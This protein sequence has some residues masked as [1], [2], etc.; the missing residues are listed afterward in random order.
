MAVT[1]TIRMK[2]V[3][4]QARL[5]AFFRTQPASAKTEMGPNVIQFTYGESRLTYS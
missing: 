2:S 1:L 5:G 4:T 3:V